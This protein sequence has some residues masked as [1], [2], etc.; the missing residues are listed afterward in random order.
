MI[1]KKRPG[2]FFL[3]M[4]LIIFAIAVAGIS[5]P[6]V[7]TMNRSAKSGKEIATIELFL[8]AP[9][10]NCREDDKFR[11]EIAGQL[12]R[13]GYEN[14]E[15]KVY[16]V[17]KENGASHFAK[18][19]DQYHLDLTLMD[20]P[21]AVVDGAVYQGSYQ[22][23]GQALFRHFE[24]GATVEERTPLSDSGSDD[25][26]SGR[27]EQITDSAFYSDVLAVEKEDTALVLFVTGACENCRMAQDYL[28]NHR[29]ERSELFVYSLLDAENVNVFQNLVRVYGVAERE[30]QVPLLFTRAGYLSGAEAIIN[31]TEKALADEETKG[32]WDETI[33]SLASVKEPLFLSKPLSKMQLII[34]GFI[35]GL[36]PCGIS[37]LLMVLSVLLMSNRSFFGGS[38]TFLAGKFLTYLVLG[39]SI[40]TFL[41]AMESTVFWT[42]QKG[43]KIIFAIFAFSFGVFYLIDFI[44]VRKKE[45]GRVRLQLPER[46]RRWNHER[47]GQLAKIPGCFRYPALFLLGVVISAGEFL[48]TGQ[49]YLAELLYLTERSKGFGTEFAGDLI[50]YLIAMCIPMAV[51]VV[52]VSKGKSVVSASHLSVKL[53]PVIK[54]AYSV[55]FFV[56]FITLLL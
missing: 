7:G 24:N 4:M 16:N 37:M 49:V 25:P 27:R 2:K 9:C 30:R 42:V 14:Q 3:I 21:V 34:T 39:V 12:T 15:F 52:L 36:N 56:L 26:W 43:L 19:A 22:E 53:L 31:G 38:F 8:L 1:L 5:V 28:E 33:E 46:F 6:M 50:L 35:N 10:E 17:Y 54:L 51:F 55:F 44:H 29:S 13:A 45:Y 18:T 20:L 41:A 40:G 47:I 23:I 48:C 32:S 11:Q